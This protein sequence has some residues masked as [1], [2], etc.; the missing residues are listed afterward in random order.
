MFVFRVA[1]KRP[2]AGILELFKNV[3][4]RLVIVK[5]NRIIIKGSNMDV[6][7]VIDGEESSEAF[8]GQRNNLRRITK[9][10]PGILSSD[11]LLNALILIISLLVMLI[12]LKPF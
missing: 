10:H 5:G 11:W 9:P 4:T 3:V 8:S 7:D 6:S 12:V 2:F 1:L